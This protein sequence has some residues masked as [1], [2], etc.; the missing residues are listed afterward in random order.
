MEG[1]TAGLLRCSLV[2][3]TNKLLPDCFSDTRLRGCAM[4]KTRIF[5]P[6]HFFPGRF[7]VISSS[8]TLL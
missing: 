8:C 4:V 7:H 2:Y 5:P 1:S 6:S 3:T